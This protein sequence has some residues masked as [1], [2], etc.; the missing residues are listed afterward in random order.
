MPFTVVTQSAHPSG[1]SI[2]HTGC[3]ECGGDWYDNSRNALCCPGKCQSDHKLHYRR[4]RAK[5]KKN[6]H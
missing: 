1:E 4:E 6:V 3:L 5:R 2:H